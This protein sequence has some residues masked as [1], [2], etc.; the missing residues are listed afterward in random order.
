MKSKIVVDT[1]ALLSPLTGIGRYTYEICDQLKNKDEF[2]L[3]F[4]Y[5]YFSKNIIKPDEVSKTKNFKN[6][7]SKTPLL[8]KVSRKLLN[9]YTT[10]QY[11]KNFDI[12]WQPN[13]I[14]NVNIKSKFTVTSV[15]DFSFLHHK[16]FHPKERIEYF[17][18]Y[19]FEN[20]KKSDL[21]ITG[22]EFIKKEILNHIDIDKSKVKVVYHGIDHNVFKKYDE[23]DLSINLPKNFLLC[24]GSLEPRK[25]LY[26]LLKSYELLPKYIKEEYKLVLVGFSGWENSEILEI[27]NKNKNY[28]HYLGYVTNEE[29]AM[30]YNL[31]KIF[32]YP[33]LYEG[34]GLPPIEAMAC[35]VPVITSENSPMQEVCKDYATYINPYEIDDIVSKLK[36]LIENEKYRSDKST[37]AIQHV[38]SFTW[39]K[40]ATE[41]SKI[42]KEGK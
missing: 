25:N 1:L 3:D 14:P 5:C 35:G 26:R 4:Y 8:K 21:I 27:I 15:H 34:F 40:S 24:V 17:Q 33:S 9:T 18:K 31:A 22:S 28:I 30:I 12:Y 10:L 20:I 7:L 29:L 11:K 32:I 16:E 38:Q 42:F 23:I 6:F 37:D 2:D 19:F 41:H 13:F 39:E 36:F